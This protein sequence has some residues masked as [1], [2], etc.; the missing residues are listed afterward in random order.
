MSKKSNPDEKEFE[1]PKEWVKETPKEDHRVISRALEN[2]L[3]RKIMK[4][5]GLESE[6]KLE[7]IIENFDLH[8]SEARTHMSYLEE[9]EIVEKTD[10]DTSTY[11]LASIGRNYL[12][13]VE[14]V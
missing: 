2:P 10:E 5:I 7:E 4:F 1:I 6:K 8:A 13:N 12:K 9:A 3:R 14:N 11:K